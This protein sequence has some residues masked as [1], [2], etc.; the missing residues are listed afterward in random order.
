MQETIKPIFIAVEGIEGSGK[1]TITE[2]IQYNLNRIRGSTL[3][4]KTLGGTV[5][6]SHLRQDLFSR[7]KVTALREIYTMALAQIDAE[8]SIVKP[9]LQ[10]NQSIIMDRYHA[11]FFVNNVFNYPNEKHAYEFFKQVLIDNLTQPDYYI[12]CEVKPEIA[13][14]RINKRNE[15]KNYIDERPLEFHQRMCTAFV[16]FF[17]NYVRPDKL[18]ILD[19]NKPLNDVKQQLF[20]QFLNKGIITQEMIEIRKPL[21]SAMV[22]E[23]F[24][25]V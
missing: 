5:I 2:I 22:D 11:S 16:Q 4:N 3:K 18:I 17:F 1:T 24:A 14:E 12:Y 19:C 6:S 25:L 8:E 10:N 9:A 23:K 13:Q 20:Q 21:F 15:A 7:D